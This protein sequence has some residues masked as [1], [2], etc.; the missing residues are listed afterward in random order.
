MSFGT[1]ILGVVSIGTIVRDDFS[2]AAL[3]I[4]KYIA[5]GDNARAMIS[6]GESEARGSLLQFRGE[7]NASQS[8][9]VK[10]TLDSIVPWY[11]SWAKNFIGLFL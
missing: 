4:G 6:L 1:I 7:L 3:S 9:L 10:E 11:L 2:L 8:R 5:I